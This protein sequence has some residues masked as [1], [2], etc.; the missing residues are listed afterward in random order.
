[1]HHDSSLHELGFDVPSVHTWRHVETLLT[2]SPK[3]I[4]RYW[5]IFHAITLTGMTKFVCRSILLRLT[6]VSNFV[7]NIKTHILC[8]VTFFENSAFYKLMWKRFYSWSVHR[9]LMCISFWILKDT[10]THWECLIIIHFPL[11]HLLHEGGLNLPFIL[12]LLL[13]LEIW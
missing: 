9:W 3:R 2:P 11:Q 13:L 5:I 6:N 10:N 8:S 7:E 4:L 1:M 12:S